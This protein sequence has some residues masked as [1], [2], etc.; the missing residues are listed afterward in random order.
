M[1]KKVAVQTTINAR[2]AEFL[3]EPRQ[4][5]LEVLRGVADMDPLIDVNRSMMEGL[6]PR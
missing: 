2:E 4:S 5:L 6:S 1:S 3:C